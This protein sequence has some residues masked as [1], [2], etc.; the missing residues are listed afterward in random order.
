MRDRVGE[1]MLV[2]QGAAVTV[3]NLSKVN[4]KWMGKVENT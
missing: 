1:L 4:W 2:R 3:F